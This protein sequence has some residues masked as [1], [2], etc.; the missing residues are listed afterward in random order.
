MRTGNLLKSAAL[1][2]IVM[3][4]V[5]SAAQASVIPDRVVKAAQDRVDSG[6]YPALV[7]GMVV[8][9]KAEVVAFGKLPDGKAPD[10]DTVFEIGSISK[11]FTATLLAESVTKKQHAL[12]DPLAKLLP[13]FTIPS[14]NGKQITLADIATQHSGLPRLPGN[15]APSDP[16]NPYADYDASRL[17]AFLARY[18]LPRDPGASYEYSNLAFGLLGYALATDAHTDYD[19]LLKRDILTP[20]G[21]R[22][23]G[24]AFTDTMR[25]HLAP[26]HDAGGAPAK[27]WDLATLAGAGAIRSTANDMLR[28]LRANMGADKTPLVDAM[29]LAHT[30]R[31]DAFP[32][33]RIGLAWMTRTK[34]GSAIVWHNG[35]TGGYAAFMGFTTDGRNGVVILTNAAISADD[36]GFAALGDATPLAPA[37][38]VVTMSDAELD[39]YLGHYK[40]AD[41]FI[42]SVFRTDHQLYALATGQGAIP[43]FPSA[44]NEF[45]ARISGISATFT[46][47]AKGAV[48]ALILHQNGDKTAPRMADA[49]SVALDAAT[50]AGYTGKYQLAPGA[51]LDVTVQKDELFVQLT[52]QPAFPVYASAKDHFF[53][54]V[55]DAKIDFERDASGAIVTL[56]LHQNGKD[57]RSPRL[58]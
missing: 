15:L 24:V 12:D 11:T 54:K 19:T 51:I 29:T 2:A 46:R 5:F 50:L 40:L 35:M 16:G 8:N 10:G 9:G 55:V 31:I 48:N 23:S 17:K 42:I 26:G 37:Q 53:Y 3:T 39:Q 34:A 44:P 33:N 49:M 32:D 58:P 28:Y 45:F 38:K 1:A 18:Q 56:V 13:D 6:Q 52:G 36:L 43:I 21:M 25:A 7:I 57:L 22:Q 47:D 4:S 30:P 27:N 41:N 20:L 14:R